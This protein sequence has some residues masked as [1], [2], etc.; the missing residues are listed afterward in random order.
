MRSELLRGAALTALIWSS[1]ALAAEGDVFTP[2]GSAGI[3]YNSNLFALP[4]DVPA[5]AQASPTV[6]VDPLLL[7]LGLAPPGQPPSAA[8][9]DPERADTIQRYV[10]GV[11]LHLPLSEQKLRATLEGRRLQYSHFERLDHNEYL[12]DVGLDWR[13]IEILDG[14]L[15]YRRERRL[16]NFADRISTQLLIETEDVASGNFNINLT[17]EWRLETGLRARNLDTPLPGAPDFTINEKS[18]SAA[19]KYLIEETLA[20]GIYAEYLAGRFEGVP[21]AA[22]FN[23]KSG[24][25]S[26]EYTITG[27]SRLTAQLGYTSRNDE[28]SSEGELSGVTGTLAYHRELSGKTALDV[29]AFRRVFSYPG[30]ASSVIEIGGGPSLIWKPTEKLSVAGSYLYTQDRFEEASASTPTSNR[31]D[32]NQ[33]ATLKLTYQIL[34]WMSVRPYAEYRERESSIAFDTYNAEI[35]GIELNIRF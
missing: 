21:N 14:M 8:P 10:A 22:N 34:P 24:G 31:T 27:L 17:P 5:A 25:V 18:V 19:I 29:Q 13:L 20:A 12:L 23:Q 11:E 28:S 26:V 4:D 1:A 15:D 9:K 35:V 30:G 33:N 32:H 2:Y 16:G 6:L 3:E 7:L